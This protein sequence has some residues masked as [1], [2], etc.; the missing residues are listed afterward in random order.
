MPPT[1]SLYSHALSHLIHTHAHTLWLKVTTP[2]LSLCSLAL[3]HPM[4]THT[5]TLPL[6]L[7]G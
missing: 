2:T 7:S 6:S 3:S 1:L 4:H 5:H